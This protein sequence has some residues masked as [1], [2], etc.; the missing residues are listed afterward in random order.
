MVDDDLTL[1]VFCNHCQRE[2]WHTKTLSGRPRNCLTCHREFAFCNDCHQI[3]MVMPKN[4]SFAGWSN[5]TTGGLHAKQAQY[6][7]DYC[8]SCHSDANSDIVCIRCHGK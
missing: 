7:F 4:H 5:T 1:F 3:E 2:T 6:D 8:Q